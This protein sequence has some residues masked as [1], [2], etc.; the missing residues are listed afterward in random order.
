MIFKKFS[1]LSA[2]LLAFL[3]FSCSTYID[4]NTN[5]NPLNNQVSP[6]PLRNPLATIQAPAFIEGG[7]P[8]NRKLIISFSKAMDT[9]IFWDKLIITDSMGKNLK[10]HF[11]KPV[12]SNEDCLV[13]ISPNAANPI[14]LKNKA[15]F[16]IYVTI[17]NTITDKEGKAL[18]NPI[19]YRYRIN[20]S[21]DQE[22]PLLLKAD[23]S[24][25][26]KEGQL[27]E[28]NLDKICTANHINSKLDF[29]FE[30]KDS[31]DGEVWA[32][33]LYQR[34]YDVNGLAV[35][36][37]EHSKLIKLSKL[38]LSNSYYENLTFDLSDSRYSDGMYKVTAYA[39]DACGNL[40]KDFLS[41][42]IIRDT[43]ILSSPNTSINFSIPQ[44]KEITKAKLDYY[45]NL[46]NFNNLED[47]VYFV[48][49]FAR[50]AKV[51]STK[52]S[53]FTYKISWG[54]SLAQM[55]QS[56][57]L[58]KGDDGY[59][60]SQEYKNF[61]QRNI[62][63]DIYLSL[64]YTD[65]VGNSN[66]I[67]TVI[68]GQINFFNY[69]VEEGSQKNLKTIKLNFSDLS[70][71][72]AKFSE[73][74]DNQAA[75]SYRLYYAKYQ[76]N[77]A[78]DSLLLTSRQPSVSD[79]YTFEI[80]DNSLYLVYIQPLYSLLSKTNGQWCGNTFG[81]LYELE[82]D[83]ISSGENPDNYTFTISK[84]SN[85]PNTA[86]FTINVD[87]Q[88]A[89]SG[90]KYYP[91]FSTDGEN[92]NTYNELSFEVENPLRAPIKAGENW[93]LSSLW[94]DRNFF[95]ARKDLENSYSNVI[96]RVKILAVKGNK[97][98]YS[99]AKELVF[100][101]DEDNIPP[102]VSDEITSHDSMLSFDG[103]SFIF[104]GIIREDDLNTQETYRYYFT[105]YNDVWG[106]NLSVMTDEQIKT[107]QGGVSRIS[108]KVW[109]AEDSSLQYSFSPVVPVN[110]LKDGKYMFFAKIND[111]YGNQSFI[112]LGK[113][114]IGTFSNKL[115]VSYDSINNQ[116][117]GRLMLNDDE[118][119]FDRNM[120]NIQAFDTEKGWYDYYGKQNELQDCSVDLRAKE[121]S[122]ITRQR[123][124]KRGSFYRI[125]VQSFNENPYNAE[126][127][128][129]VNK[130]N[131]KPYSQLSEAAKLL[132]LVQNETE[133]DLYT[134]E[135]VSNP[136]YYYV[137]AQDEDMSRF[138]GSF[139]K[140]TAAISSNKPVIINLVSS[141]YDL[142]S[143]IDN[144]ERRG[145]LIKTYYFKG[146]S[147]G[148]T[149]KDNDVREDLLNSDEEGLIYYVMVVH[150][151]NNTSEI[152]NVYTM[153]K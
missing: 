22:K 140:N 35:N 114:N 152:S 101:R 40:S 89:Q 5:T 128:S 24:I 21:L 53:A 62:N 95:E 97:A 123:S 59:E 30:A 37:I 42:Y 48:S 84:T 111:T 129:G 144:W 142:G 138:K 153:Q 139:F 60:L 43:S 81:P 107:L 29:D 27:T 99:K 103:R 20:D 77:Q 78:K 61:R 122:A 41:W 44:D 33:F 6:S 93:A 25:S 64:T 73:L 135:K 58:V 151:A 31:G 112:T 119:K 91:C 85:G 113:A 17:S 130:I 102:E 106:S 38:S 82:A 32:R 16:D 98:V 94:K 49:S 26:L 120:I 148:I 133:Y 125:S 4:E 50:E 83:T 75:V 104:D 3:T 72:A 1:L 126:S 46:I 110:G 143:D 96:A 132:P 13:E 39:I 146:D 10:E 116:F 23:S 71:T 56:Q 80:E 8:K 19:D 87:I 100:T 57:K 70:S 28:E 147:G 115:N 88:N 7:L 90:V 109:Q 63:K 9:E 105:E 118:L 51:Y 55:S 121:L 2:V 149:F 117:T 124:L 141:L 11:N 131:P 92:W 136:V 65:S 137:P 18:K 145:K 68:P 12:W 69:E 66:T 45:T 14:D 108:P 36:D 76:K 79:N 52:K 127:K 86:S 34:I 15:Y 47:D 134:D 74:P 150:F 54:L 67:N